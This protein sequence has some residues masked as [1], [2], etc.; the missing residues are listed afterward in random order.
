MKILII[1][2]R[3]RGGV[4]RANSEIAD[5]LRKEGHEVDILS[6]ED[7]LKKYSLTKSIFPLRRKVKKLMNEKNYDV[8]Y[9]QDYSCAIP[10]IM[11]YPLFWKK[12]FSCFC[13]IKTG[14]H[15]YLFQKHQKILQKSV[16]NIMGNKLVVIG[17]A[18][19]E[20]FPKSNLIYRGV[21]LENFKPLKKK[22]EFLG[23]VSTDNETISHEEIKEISKKTGLG[24]I[25]AKNIP[26]EKMNEFYNKCKVFVNF[27]RTAGF[28]LAWL[29]AMAAGVPIII[30]NDKGA[31]KFLPI[32]KT[33]SEDRVNEIVRM[34]KNPKKINYRDWLIDN[35]FTWENKSKELLNFLQISLK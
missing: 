21:N 5:A 26:K 6:R 22:R 4:G 23:W 8:I 19:K 2:L 17:D 1:L 13:G 16:G 24:L 12:H 32:D 9:T 14:E 35:R 20:R 30:G 27:P 31:G 11:P 15:P 10:L 25:I 33:L 7:D 28:N 18:L 3:L 34:I 29:E